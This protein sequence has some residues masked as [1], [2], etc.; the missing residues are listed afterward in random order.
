MMYHFNMEK[1]DNIA[2][3]KNDI[4][5]LLQEYH[6]LFRFFWDYGDCC[7]SCQ[8]PTAWINFDRENGNFVNF[9]FNPDFYKS[10]DDY[11]RA[12]VCSHEMLH[13]MLEHGARMKEFATKKTDLGNEKLLNQAT[14]IVINEMLID[15]FGFNRNNIKDWNKYCWID[16]LFE[17]ITKVEKNKNFQYY[18]ELL[19]KKENLKNKDENKN[20][21]QDGQL[22]DI[23]NFNNLTEEEQKQIMDTLGK[24]AKSISP[25]EMEKFFKNKEEIESAKKI[26]ENL[27]NMK[28]GIG[29][30]FWD[31]LKIGYVKKKKK[32]ETVIKTWEKFVLKDSDTEYERWDR[33][34]R[35]FLDILSNKNYLLPTEVPI[36]ELYLDKNKISI[37]FFLDTSGSCYNLKNRFFKAAKSLDEKHFDIRLFCFD[38]TV[39]E[40]TLKSQ[41]I[42]GGGGTCFN[43]IENKIQEIIKKEKKS[44]PKA[45]FLITDGYGTPVK[46]QYP[47]RWHWFLSTNYRQYIPKESK[48]YMLSDFE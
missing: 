11:N 16:T 12:F 4:A 23:H 8:Y 35:R 5:I 41:K 17:D 27:E 34:N 32:W 33:K 47:K 19:K 18:Y 6:S 3:N 42:Y 29:S 28:A 39:N 31:T 38:N 1:K 44:Y 20:D 43:I 14:D 24:L 40:T 15:A 10:L 21:E 7:F 37:Y 9:N 46:P 30:G 13:I 45:L 2:F 22:V 25:E 26:N 36:E 48:I